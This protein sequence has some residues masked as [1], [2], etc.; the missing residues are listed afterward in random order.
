M[1]TV[2]LFRGRNTTGILTDARRLGVVA[3]VLDPGELP[4]RRLGL[5]R[6]H[7]EPDHGREHREQA[8]QEVDVGQCVGPVQAPAAD[9][10]QEGEHVHR[11]RSPAWLARVALSCSKVSTISAAASVSEAAAAS[12]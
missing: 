1:A 7:H 6:G 3:D 5:E 11:A 8:H 4:E 12:P 10:G 2:V 9:A